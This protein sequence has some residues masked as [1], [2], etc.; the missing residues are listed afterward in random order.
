MLELGTSPAVST[1]TLMDRVEDALRALSGAAAR[2]SSGPPGRAL[3]GPIV[4]ARGAGRHV[5]LGF[6]DEPPFARITALG[7]GSYGLAFA[8]GVERK[9]ELLLVDD[10]R[11]VVEHAL[12]GGGALE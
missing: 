6:E 10:L 4:R 3:K 1:R 9:W 7:A 11:S 2:M 8:G 5:L 12:V